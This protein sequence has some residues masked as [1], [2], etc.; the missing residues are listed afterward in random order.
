MCTF[1]KRGGN[2][3]FCRLVTCNAIVFS[4]NLGNTFCLS[5]LYVILRSV[6]LFLFDVMSNLFIPMKQSI[7]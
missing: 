4:L 3:V 1:I 6:L 5:T 2:I 7:E